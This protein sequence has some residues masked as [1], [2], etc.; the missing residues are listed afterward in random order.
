MSK[1]NTAHKICKVM[2]HHLNY[3]VIS[4]N[5]FVIPHG[6]NNFRSLYSGKEDPS[7]IDHIATGIYSLF[8]SIGKIPY[9]R[10]A[11]GEISD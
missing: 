2:S 8:K 10:V 6:K 4:P 7:V 9:I 11:S 3:Q 1:T 5:F